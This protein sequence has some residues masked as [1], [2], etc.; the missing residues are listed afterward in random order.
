ML[1]DMDGT[2]L[3]LAFDNFFWLDLVPLHYAKENSLSETAAR[4]EL[5][6]RYQEL[7]GS[8]AWY[9]IDHWSETLALDIRAL[10][11]EHQ[12]RICFL[13]GAMEFLASVRRRGKRLLV[14]TNAH[15]D[16]LAIKVEQ[17]AL[18]THVHGLVSSHDFRAPKESREFWNKFRAGE[19][20]DPE[21]SVLIEDS[22]PVLQAASAFG[23]KLTV[24]IRR[25]DSRY[26][27]RAIDA[28]PAVDGVGELTEE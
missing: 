20:F 9:C 18:D 19:Q 25:P 1:V 28:F 6:A 8:L 7:E 27:P 5:K 11:R 26:P 2:L 24:A 14:V 10:K 15:R 13:P 22:L 21:R 3:D 12:H 17:T 4:E 16:T 23:L